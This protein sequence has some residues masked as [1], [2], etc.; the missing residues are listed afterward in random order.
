MQVDI[1]VALPNNVEPGEYFMSVV[2]DVDNVVTQAPGNHTAVAG[3][4]KVGLGVNKLREVSASVTFSTVAPAST[5]AAASCGITGSL[6][7]TG[8]SSINDPIF[9]GDGSVTATGNLTLDDPVRSATFIGTF[10]VAVDVNNLATLSFAF[11]TVTLPGFSGTATATATGSIKV[12]SG[13]GQGGGA[14][15][16]LGFAFESAPNAFRGQLTGTGCGFVGSFKATV[17]QIFDLFFLNFL[18]A[19]AFGKTDLT[20]LVRFPV[21]FSSYE[22]LLSVVDSPGTL[23]SPDTVRFTGPNGSNLNDVPADGGSSGLDQADGFAVYQTP[24]IDSSTGPPDGTYTVT[25]KGGATFEA[26]PDA[27]RRAVIPLP[28]VTLNAARDLQR[29]S[30]QYHSRETG[31]RISTPP[32]IGLIGFLISSVNSSGTL[33]FCSSPFFDRTVTSF[34]LIPTAD[35]PKGIH[36][37]DVFMLSFIYIDSLTINAYGVSFDGPRLSFPELAVGVVGSGTV[38]SSPAGISCGTQ[39]LAS[40]AR[41][42][43]VNLTATPA[44]GAIFLGWAGACS[45]ANRSCLV[46]MSTD[47]IVGAAFATAPQVRFL[48]R[49]CVA[50]DCA[51]YTATLTSSLGESHTWSSVSE[52]ASPYQVVLSTFLDGFTVRQGAPFNRT[53]QFAGDPFQLTPG[54]K[55]TLVL[56]VDEA[57]QGYTLTLVNTTS[58][59]TGQGTKSLQT[60]PIA[61]PRVPSSAR[62]VAPRSP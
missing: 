10:N 4:F 21:P 25:Y 46:T 3:P 44:S 33:D 16:G 32:F 40:F 38:I 54:L 2:A 36:W 29:V 20:P 30:W 34:A 27:S 8:G 61:G 23:P 52:V 37:D 57:T 58:A 12:S 35:C 18:D 49:T 43:V 26:S 31:A 56:D 41:G 6:N 59:A 53:L 47:Q 60:A 9:N 24:S 11:D 50:P 22:A 14:G 1:D 45:G 51:P 62:P 55:Y 48:N 39:C 7:L 15:A 13:A 28:T 17:E 42:S 19:G 5:L